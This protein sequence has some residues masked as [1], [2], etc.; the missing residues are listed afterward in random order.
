MVTKKS[1]IRGTRE[2]AVAGVNC[3][4]GCPHDCRYCYARYKSVMTSEV[5]S[6]EQWS[7]SR[8]RTEEAARDY[9]LY[10]GTVMFPTEHDIHPEVLGECLSVLEKLIAAGNKVLVVSKPH[11]SCIKEICRRFA[12][13]PE[14]ILFRFT[15]TAKDNTILRFWEPGAPSFEERLSCLSHAFNQEYSTSV[16]IEPMLECENIMELIGDLTPYTTHSIW[17]GKMN[18][19]EERVSCDSATMHEEIERIRRSQSDENIVKLY[20]RLRN[21]T[22]IRWKESIKEVV[23][24]E[25]AKQPGLDI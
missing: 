8:I 17:L 24:L 11:F 21:N 6:S 5:E 22:L 25:L 23:G 1:T 9:P 13:S 15:I 10:P 16:S 2:W 12:A 4:L 14:K 7:Q 18:K 19:I 3:S 20:T